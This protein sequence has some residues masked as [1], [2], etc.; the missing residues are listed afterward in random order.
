MEPHVAG[1]WKP[2]RRSVTWCLT[3]CSEERFCLLH[4]GSNFYFSTD[5]FFL[6][7]WDISQFAVV[8]L[9][10][11]LC[12]DILECAEMPRLL[13]VIQE[14]TW[15]QSPTTANQCIW[16]SFI[17]RNHRVQP[18]WSPT[19]DAH[20]RKTTFAIM[21]FPLPGKYMK[22]HISTRLALTYDF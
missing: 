20:P 8:G 11:F 5:F 17:R 22:C 4:P 21:L 15:M 18:I 1:I 10:L 9:P 2:H 13:C 19:D 6:I 7:C 12:T 16:A 3:Q 14:R